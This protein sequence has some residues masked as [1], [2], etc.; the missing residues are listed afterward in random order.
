MEMDDHH[1][2]R[3]PFPLP[4]HHFKERFMQH[5]RHIAEWGHAQQPV[6]HD[7]QHRGHGIWEGDNTKIGDRHMDHHKH[8]S[9]FSYNAVMD[10][11]HHHGHLHGHRHGLSGV[12]HHVQERIVEGCHML[13]QWRHAAMSK[14]HYVLATTW[15]HAF[16]KVAGL[17]H[18]VRGHPHWNHGWQKDHHASAMSK[19]QLA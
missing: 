18:H 15:H 4:V 13:S 19:E 5:G 17:W 3:H 7:Q 1:H 10:S 16:H 14:A 12:A 9:A 11:H 8:D 6:E 2:H